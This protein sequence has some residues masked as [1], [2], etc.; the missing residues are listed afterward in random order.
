[1]TDAN[2]FLLQDSYY[3]VLEG[4]D[5]GDVLFPL[6]E[7]CI[8]LADRA[9]E[10]RR[11]DQAPAETR[12]SSVC[13]YDALK[14]HYST[15]RSIGVSMYPNALGLLTNC[16]LFSYRAIDMVDNIGWWGGAYEVTY[17]PGS[18]GTVTDSS[19][20]LEISQ[21]PDSHYQSYTVHLQ[22]VETE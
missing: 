7:K 9:F 12:S 11:S 18:C 3:F 2:C 19:S 22:H 5:S 6:H 17:I 10:F 14:S 15:A 21:R 1:M 4:D 8:K 16:D 13:L 20:H